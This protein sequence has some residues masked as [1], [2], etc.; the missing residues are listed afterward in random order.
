M[1]FYHLVSERAE[2]HAFVEPQMPA[3]GAPYSL[4]TF[5]QRRQGNTR[6]LGPRLVFEAYVPGGLVGQHECT[7]VCPARTKKLQRRSVSTPR[8]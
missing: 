6:Y 3:Q 7:G 5:I 4:F 8:Y 1:A 2:V